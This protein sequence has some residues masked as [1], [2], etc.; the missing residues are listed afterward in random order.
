MLYSTFKKLAF[1]MD[2]ESAH[3]STIKMVHL[4]PRT[5]AKMLPGVRL[6]RGQE[7]RYLVSSQNLK[8]KFPIGVA[9]GLDKNG[10]ATS[11][12]SNLGF[13]AVEVGTITLY[14]Q[15]GNPK[16][17]IF[18]YPQWESFRNSMGFPNLGVENTL[19]SIQEFYNEN[20]RWS[21]LGI[22]LGINK[23]RLTDLTFEDYRKLYQLLSPWSDYLVI[24]ISSPN[25]EGLRKWQSQERLIVLLEALQDLRKNFKTPL[26]IKI[27]PELNQEEISS[28]VE[29][30]KRYQLAGIVATNTMVKLGLGSG[31]VSGKLVYQKADKVRKSIL[32]MIK[33]TPEV[34]LI[35]VG[36]FFNFD[37]VVD[38]WQSGGKF[39]QIYTSFVYKGP[40]FLAEIQKGIDQLLQKHQV[41]KLEEL[42]QLVDQKQI[43]LM[44]G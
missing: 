36:G 1:Q 32:S 27:A 43:N 8:W 2:P 42:L 5:C 28:V 3:D 39:V 38:F 35:G 34:D 37:Q 12:F 20:S 14:P 19:N 11:Y 16:P 40:P 15:E 29:V 21:S 26:F 41:K 17:R 31:G 23:E 30:V 25:T 9:A 10:E 6:K 18:R 44:N 33:E 4:F 24:N 22:N 13:G 7:E